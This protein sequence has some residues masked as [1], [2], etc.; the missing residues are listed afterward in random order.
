MKNVFGQSHGNV[1]F[2]HS[3][4]GLSWGSQGPWGGQKDSGDRQPLYRILP[5][6]CSG[7]PL[8]ASGEKQPRIRNGWEQEGSGVGATVR[9]LDLFCK[10]NWSHKRVL[11]R[12]DG[13]E[14]VGKHSVRL[15]LFF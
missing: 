9:T 1:I 7:T 14:E 13:E 11:S 8:C 10:G 12:V 2:H 3:S 4:S 6:L 15:I 5:V